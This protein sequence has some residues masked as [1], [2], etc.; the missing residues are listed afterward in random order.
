LDDLFYKYGDIEDIQIIYD[1]SVCFSNLLFLKALEL[2]LTYYFQ[3]DVSKGFGFVYFKREEDA[4]KA[5]DSL[6]GIVCLCRYL[7]LVKNTNIRLQELD[8][9]KLRIDYSTTTRPHTP[10]PGVYMGRRYY[11]NIFYYMSQSIRSNPN[12]FQ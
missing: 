2:N 5:K 10:T 8:G 11:I 6:A 7:V 9:R 1:K 4:A 3:T 12:C